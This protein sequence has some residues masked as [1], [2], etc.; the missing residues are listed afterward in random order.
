MNRNDSEQVAVPAEL[1]ESFN[2]GAMQ[3]SLYLK[4]SLHCLPGRWRNSMKRLIDAIDSNVPLEQAVHQ[5]QNK[6]PGEFHAILLAALQLP[7]PGKFVLHTMNGRMERQR[8]TRSLV[9]VLTYPMALLVAAILLSSAASFLLAPVLIQLTE[10]FGLTGVNKS[11]VEDQQAASRGMLAVFFWTMLVGLSLRWIGPKWASFSV[12]SGLPYLGK[13]LRWISLYEILHRLEGVAEQGLGGIPALQRVA[14]SFVSS[15][16]EAAFLHI[17][18]R[19]EAGMCIGASLSR[20][21]LSDGLC[22]PVLLSLDHQTQGRPDFS[23]AAHVLRRLSEIRLNTLTTIFPFLA[24]VL[25]VSIVVGTV[26]S[27]V[28]LLVNF[29]RVLAAF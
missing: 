4:L 18:R 22:G 11:V 12:W 27:Y 2:V 29:I 16:L 23:R 24:F 28:G 9:S 15:P 1:L 26:S 13:A 7:E 21:L 8:L 25:I 20:S 3:E 17:L 19:N 14:D 6:L 5:F 10:D